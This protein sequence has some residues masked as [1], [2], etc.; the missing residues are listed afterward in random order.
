MFVCVVVTTLYFWIFWLILVNRMSS[1]SRFQKYA[2][3]G[4]GAA[5]GIALYYFNYYTPPQIVQNSWTTSYDPGLGKW[6]FNWDQYAFY[7][8]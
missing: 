2:F 1:F 3:I 4:L 7:F 5:S 8:L 6:D